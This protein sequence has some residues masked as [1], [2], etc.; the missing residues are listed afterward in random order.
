MAYYDH[1]KGSDGRRKKT[2][3]QNSLFDLSK[4]DTMQIQPKKKDGANRPI[5]LV[6]V[7]VV[8]SF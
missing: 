8:P 2:K 7:Q 5:G 1:I 6:Q 3:P 4:N